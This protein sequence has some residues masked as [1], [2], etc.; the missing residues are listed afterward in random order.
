MI[1]RCIFSFVQ[2]ISRILF[3]GLAFSLIFI[4]VANSAES[5]N[6]SNKLA[7]DALKGII[8]D[9]EGFSANFYQE[10]SDQKGEVVVSSNGSIY[11]KKPD[12]FL[13]HTIEPD[14]VVLFTRNKN[15]YYFD[16]TINQVTVIPFENMKHNPFLLLT[17]IDGLNWN[18]Y[19]VSKDEQRFTLIPNTPQDI[20]SI[21]LAFEPEGQN[22]LL[23]SIS[24]RMDDGNTNFY[25]FTKRSFK[26]DSKI[27]DYQLPDDVEYDNN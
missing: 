6:G 12:L 13:M 5:A 11:L 18:D 1:M 16:E 3:W 10:V 23:K 22:N 4:G 7:I 26:V 8:K 21:T 15:I 19:I 14:E 20:K 17:N 2:K 24:L 9:M 27:F 25:N